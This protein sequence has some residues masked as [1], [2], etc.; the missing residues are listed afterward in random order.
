[1][2]ALLA[3]GRLDVQPIIG[4]VWPLEQWHKAFEQMHTGQVVKSVL[5]PA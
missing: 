4:G 1:V 2:I 3:G 5:A